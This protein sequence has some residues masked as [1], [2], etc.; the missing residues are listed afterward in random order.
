MQNT[1]DTL[2]E[3]VHYFINKDGKWVFTETYHLNRGYC[4]KSGCVNCP[5]GFLKPK[6]LVK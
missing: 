1:N 5:Y 2:L 3:G 4:C 6:D